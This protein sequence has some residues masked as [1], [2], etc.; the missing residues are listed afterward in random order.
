MIWPREKLIF[1]VSIFFFNL[2]LLMRKVEDLGLFFC[3]G[4][5]DSM[6]LVWNDSGPPWTALCEVLTSISGEISQNQPWRDK[7]RCPRTNRDFKFHFYR[8]CA[9][10]KM[11]LQPWEHKTEQPVPSNTWEVA[12]LCV[13]STFKN[14]FGSVSKGGRSFSS[15]S[16]HLLSFSANIKPESN[17]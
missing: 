7:D 5:Q 1:C 16:R 17:I 9:M 6:V 2:M 12:A 14:L 11:C 3:C 10:T 15:F 8:S 4:P 13:F